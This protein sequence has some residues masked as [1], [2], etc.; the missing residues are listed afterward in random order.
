MAA[1]LQ[2]HGQGHLG[3][4]FETT[5]GDFVAPT[6]FLPI[7]SESLRWVEDK[8]YRMNIKGVADR[9]PPGTLGPG[10]VE[11]DVEF[12]VTADTLI[13]FLYAGRMEPSRTGVG[14][15]TYTFVPFHGPKPSTG[16][17]ATVRKTLSILV[18]RANVGFGYAGCS[19][20]SFNFSYEN[21]VLI[22]SMSLMGLTEGTETI[23]SPTFDELTDLS[24][25]PAH[26]S[27]KIPSDEAIRTDVADASLSINDGAE[28]RARLDGQQAPSGIRWGEREVTV[29]LEHDFESTADY[30]AFKASTRQDIEFLASRDASDNQIKATVRGTITDT[31][32][33]NLAS[34]GDLV[35]ASVEYHGTYDDAEVY[36]IEVKTDEDILG[37]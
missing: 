15:Y 29:S 34:L 36:E 27:I 6:K 3:L 35:A 31:Y 7:R 1:E 20:G 32:E 5:I 28:V 37:S 2:I 17:S 19:V 4:S 16:A 21:E 12:E 24:F 9:Q 18:A 23:V 33:S 25:G 30:D 14:P 13:Y 22:C 11:G 8:P 26:N 10:H